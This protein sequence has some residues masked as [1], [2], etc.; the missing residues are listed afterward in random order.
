M[1]NYNEVNNY[2]QII[3][4]ISGGKSTGQISSH[5]CRVDIS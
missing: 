1:P 3:K 2:Y 5:G 4:E